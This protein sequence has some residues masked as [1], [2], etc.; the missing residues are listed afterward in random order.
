MKTKRI[1]LTTDELIGHLKQNEGSCI[2]ASLVLR[3]GGRSTHFLNYHKGIL[4]DEGCDGERRKIT[5]K[6]L[7]D[8]YPGKLWVLWAYTTQQQ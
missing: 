2:E 8:D 4:F 7:A 3:Y 5:L 1:N 6:R